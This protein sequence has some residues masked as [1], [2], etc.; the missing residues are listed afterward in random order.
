MVTRRLTKRLLAVAYASAL[1][2][3]PLP[4]SAR[5]VI[6]DV[7]SA[8]PLAEPLQIQLGV[9]VEAAIDERLPRLT[10]DERRSYVSEALRLAATSEQEPMLGVWLEPALSPAEASTVHVVTLRP[11]GS[12]PLH[13]QFNLA[14]DSQAERA[15]ALT[16]AELYRSLERP[17]AAV[18]P[19]SSHAGPRKLPPAPPTSSNLSAEVGAG[20]MVRSYGAELWP[21]LGLQ[22]RGG[23]R[24]ERARRVVRGYGG[25]YVQLPRRRSAD[26]EALTYKE[27]AAL[28]GFSASHSLGLFEAGVDAEFR[29]ARFSV[30]GATGGRRGEVERWAGAFAIHAVGGLYASRRVRAALAAGGSLQ[31]Q[32]GRFLV[33]GKTVAELPLLAPEARLLLT[34]AW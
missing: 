26:A 2:V 33:L 25:W 14:R 23:I 28:V 16:I 12:S 20:T 7:D 27:Q 10:L 30:E 29:I 1:G 19:E 9:A 18:R 15:L 22:L 13:L 24:W 21:L 8:R 6:F 3:L 31:L 11:G 34:Y 17:V 4:A 5:V 32:P